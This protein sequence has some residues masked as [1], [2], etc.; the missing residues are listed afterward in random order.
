MV[1]HCRF[2]SLETCKC[3]TYD[4]PSGGVVGGAVVACVV[5]ACVVSGGVETVVVALSEEGKYIQSHA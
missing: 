3:C 2:K 5:V 1:L 4:I